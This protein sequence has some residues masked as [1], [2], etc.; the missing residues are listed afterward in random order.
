MSGSNA[1]TIG[2]HRLKL[3][4]CK[5]DTA[6]AVQSWFLERLELLGAEIIGSKYGGRE[7]SAKLY[8]AEAHSPAHILLK[9]RGRYIEI[10]G[11]IAGLLYGGLG[12]LEYSQLEEALSYVSDMLELDL[13]TTRVDYMEITADAYLSQPFRAYTDTLKAPAGIEQTSYRG[14][15]YF[16]RKGRT[17]T[18]QSK[19]PTKELIIYD[20]GRETG[21]APRS[22]CLLRAELKLSGGASSIAR[23]LKVSRVGG[24]RATD[25][26]APNVWNSICAQLSDFVRA[27]ISTEDVITDKE[28]M[29]KR[30]LEEAVIAEC[31]NMGFD[32]EELPTVK[33]WLSV[34]DKSARSKAKRKIKDTTQR[35]ISERA[36][37]NATAEELR[38]FISEAERNST[39]E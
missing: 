28:S 24:I 13:N 29:R 34:L 33:A 2:I 21:Q 22:G 18:R 9:Q 15:K 31:I 36:N 17:G 27:I 6:P 25:L 4:E 39:Q 7:I 35:I 12:V 11:S 14:T 38:A 19:K 26:T 3:T 10:N 1:R 32:I 16:R 8:S 5:D 37:T 23:T 30:G 20:K